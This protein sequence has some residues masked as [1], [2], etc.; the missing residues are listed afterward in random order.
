MLLRENA[1]VDRCFE[2]DD[3]AALWKNSLVLLF[4]SFCVLL[5]MMM[6]FLTPG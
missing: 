2:R 1:I 6:N 4:C 3:G 5:M